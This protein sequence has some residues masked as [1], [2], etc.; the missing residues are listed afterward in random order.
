MPGLDPG[1][2]GAVPID[3]AIMIGD[4]E[5]GVM[6]MKMDVGLDTGDDRDGQA[7]RSLDRMTASDLD[8]ELSAPA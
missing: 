5:L 8:D 7:H 3:R 2:A 6:V 4:A 1:R